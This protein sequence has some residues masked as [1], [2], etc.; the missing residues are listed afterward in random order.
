MYSNNTTETLAVVCIPA[1]HGPLQIM[2]IQG[3]LLRILEQAPL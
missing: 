2:Y 3:Y 1:D